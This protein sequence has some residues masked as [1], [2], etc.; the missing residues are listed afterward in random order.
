[1]NPLSRNVVLG[2]LGL[3]VAGLVFALV[4]SFYLDRETRLV[5]YDAYR[6]A[7]SAVAQDRDDV[8][9]RAEL[10]LANQT[11]LAHRRA[12]A[13]H[14]HSVNMGIL[15]ILIGLLA[16]LLGR[17]GKQ[18][19]WL[20]SATIGA[21]WIYPSGLLLKFAGLIAWGEALAGIGAALAIAAMLLLFTNLSRAVDSVTRS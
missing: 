8:L 9:W 2:G 11:S 19:T 3:V 20:I 15:L 21:A 7:F 13:V 18:S 16:P 14:T 10:A 17:L 5:A 1:M 12:A 6:P 4:V